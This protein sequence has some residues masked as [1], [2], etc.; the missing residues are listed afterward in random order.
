L[1]GGQTGQ[2]HVLLLSTQQMLIQRLD[3]GGHGVG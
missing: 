2:L 3:L 1:L